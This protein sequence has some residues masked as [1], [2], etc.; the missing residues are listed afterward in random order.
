MDDPGGAA[1]HAAAGSG[2]FIQVS[3]Q[4]GLTTV[5][6]VGIYSASKFAVEGL[7]Q[8]LAGEVAPFGIKV[9]IVEPAGYATDWAGP[10][11]TVATPMSAYKDVHNAISEL[12]ATVEIGVPE[13]PADA[14]LT[15]ADAEQPPLRIFF[16]RGPLEWVKASTKAASRSGRPGTTS[17]KRRSAS[18][19]SRPLRFRVATT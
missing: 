11:A 2:H 19:R 9:T 8:A 3:S 13:S 10:S 18:E 6:T 17:P 12:M 16:G 14:I 7:T 1:R 5:P 15:V 4:V